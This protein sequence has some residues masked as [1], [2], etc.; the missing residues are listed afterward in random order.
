MVEVSS[1]FAIFVALYFGVLKN[2]WG[3]CLARHWCP[4]IRTPFLLIKPVPWC[5][6][7]R[8]VT[9]LVIIPSW[10]ST[11]LPIQPSQKNP[12][13]NYLFRCLNVMLVL[14]WYLSLWRRYTGYSIFKKNLKV[15]LFFVCHFTLFYVGPDIVTL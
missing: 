7:E 2:Q 1:S 15:I 14:H 5:L 9:Y 12:G 6:K 11:A 8:S 4:D 13:P 10:L 3:S